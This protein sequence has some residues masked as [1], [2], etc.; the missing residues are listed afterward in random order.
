VALGGGTVGRLGLLARL[1]AGCLQLLSLWVLERG[2]LRGVS[3]CCRVW[4]A[5]KGR[6]GLG[7]GLGSAAGSG[8][9]CGLALAPGEATKELG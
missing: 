1:A 6:V 2:R 4:V 9:P 8:L 3:E 5:L 7:A